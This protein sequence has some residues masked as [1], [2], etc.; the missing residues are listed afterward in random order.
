MSIA[1][2]PGSFDPVTLGHLDIIRRAAPLFEELFVCVMINS[3]KTPYFTHEERKG[4]IKR[5]TSELRNVRVESSEGLLVD[6]M[7]AKGASVIIKGLRAM[8]DFDKEFQLAL[9]N[10][11]LDH[12]IETLFIPS[13]EEYTYLSSSIVKE[14]T[15]YGADLRTF[16]PQEI[17]EDL[18][19]KGK[20]ESGGN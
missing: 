14:M 18:I 15:R 9:V 4:F 3:G 11:K 17:I 13:S 16:V 8:S 19:R 7:H 1:V 6:Y 2:Y 12:F 20:S 10:R 5:T